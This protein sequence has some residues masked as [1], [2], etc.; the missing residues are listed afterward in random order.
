MS[1]HTIHNGRKTPHAVVNNIYG[2]KSVEKIWAEC[3][4]DGDENA[5]TIHKH[6]TKSNCYVKAKHQNTPDDEFRDSDIRK[7]HTAVWNQKS[8]NFKKY[9]MF[10]TNY[11]I[12]QYMNTPSLD[13]FLC[14]D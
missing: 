7:M 6:I 1:I 8:A 9:G 11:E 13:K 10:K 5:K 4:D 12:K 2:G 3:F 14:G